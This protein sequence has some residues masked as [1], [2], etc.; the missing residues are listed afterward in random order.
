MV[1]NR[2]APTQLVLRSPTAVF[3]QALNLGLPTLSVTGILQA[4]VS[5]FS[6]WAPPAWLILTALVAVL[7]A[8]VATASRIQ[9]EI[10]EEGLRFCNGPYSRS[11]SWSD[12]EAIGMCDVHI[13]G[14]VFDHCMAIRLRGAREAWPLLATIRASE[15]RFNDVEKQL[16]R[17]A[18]A[19]GVTS[20]AGSFR[21][22]LGRLACRLP[23]AL[24]SRRA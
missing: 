15:R 4:A 1:S 23:A 14:Q 3:G 5:V 18:R 20:S 21:W 6:G 17:V 13:V 11:V 8:C 7:G 24:G 12:I 9:M 16:R 19:K 2:R 10:G 22:R